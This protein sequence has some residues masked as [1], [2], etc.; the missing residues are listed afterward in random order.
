MRGG[1]CSSS[2]ASSAGEWTSRG[3]AAATAGT[4]ATAASSATSLGSRE[5]GCGAG[6]TTKFASAPFRAGCSEKPAPTP[7]CAL[8]CGVLGSGRETGDW[9]LSG[10]YKKLRRARGGGGGCRGAAP[11]PSPPTPCPGRL[12]SSSPPPGPLPSRV[13]PHSRASRPKAAA[14]AP[15]GERSASPPWYGAERRK[16]SNGAVT[17]GCRHR[18]SGAG[19]GGGGGARAE[20]GVSWGGGGRPSGDSDTAP[21]GLPGELRR[22]LPALSQGDRS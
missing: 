18:G 21:V 19:R 14:P 17:L 2:G 15:P 20:V 10:L 3:A 8:S 11:L 16:E 7:R 1:H 5:N 13:S 9:S 22:G 12:P 6:L 4:A